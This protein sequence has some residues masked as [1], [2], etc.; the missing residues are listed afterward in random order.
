MI[1]SLALCLLR[2]PNPDLR[3]DIILFLFLLLQM[4]AGYEL[5]FLLIRIWCNFDTTAFLLFLS[6]SI[7]ADG[8]L[9]K[10]KPV[11]ARRASGVFFH[12]VSL[13]CFFPVFRM[14]SPET[15]RGHH[16]LWSFHVFRTHL[17]P[18]GHRIMFLLTFLHPG[19]LCPSA[20]WWLRFMV[21]CTLTSLPLMLSYT[22]TGPL[23]GNLFLT[24][25][26]HIVPCFV[27]LVRPA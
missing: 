8:S 25:T 1:N 6:R 20:S 12:I 15:R 22:E 23:I 24:I 3:H 9:K 4:G 18:G 11:R 21:L 10:Q 2:P 17:D 5:C 26:V 16:I 19:W 14:S 27:C 13:L 7:W